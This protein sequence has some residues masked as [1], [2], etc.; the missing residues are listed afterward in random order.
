MSG[1]LHY[2]PEGEHSAWGSNGDHYFFRAC[3]PG[4]N[5]AYSLHILDSIKQD[6]HCITGM[7]GHIYSANPAFSCV[8]LGKH[9]SEYLYYYDSQTW[10]QLP[11]GWKNDHMNPVI[12]RGIWSADG[13]YVAFFIDV[14]SRRMRAISVYSRHGEHIYAHAITPSYTHTF[15]P[16]YE[17]IPRFTWHPHK[18][19]L[20]VYT[21][22]QCSWL[23]LE[24]TVRFE[25]RWDQLV[26]QGRFP[27]FFS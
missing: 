11:T 14:P 21:S 7:F 18:P 16:L 22:D 25:I 3:P 10:I 6:H 1:Y 12:N 4:S 24:G 19:I 27:Y 8:I 2:I 13:E 5:T 17:S 23:D 9:A 15:D 26:P 20:A